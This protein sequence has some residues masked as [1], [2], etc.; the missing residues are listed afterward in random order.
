MSQVQPSDQYTTRGSIYFKAWYVF[1]YQKL[2]FPLSPSLTSVIRIG[3]EEGEP[4]NGG[5]GGSGHVKNVTVEN[6]EMKGVDM[7]PYINTW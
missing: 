3:E 2:K 1:E 5:G 7:G 4:P 6:F